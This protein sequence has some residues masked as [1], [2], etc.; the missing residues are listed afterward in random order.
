MLTLAPW[1]CLVL[2]LLVAFHGSPALGKD[3]PPADAKPVP[4]QMFPAG[5]IDSAAKIGYVYNGENGVA[6]VELASG[7]ELWKSPGAMWPLMGVE[8]DLLALVRRG[9][10]MAMV[11]VDPAT[12]KVRQVSED[13]ELPAWANRPIRLNPRA[14]LLQGQLL[15]EWHVV[16]DTDGGAAPPTAY[17]RAR[18]DIASGKVATTGARE[19]FNLTAPVEHKKIGDLTFSIETKTEEPHPHFISYKRT[20]RATNSDGKVAWERQLPTVVVGPPKP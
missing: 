19:S 2:F 16:L 9:N 1:P 4:S 17:G 5:V 7:K 14:G 11:C 20:L 12:G 18:I 15:L 3:A 8:G 6:A 13:I 10:A